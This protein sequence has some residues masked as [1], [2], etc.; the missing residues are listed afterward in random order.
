[1][2][3]TPVGIVKRSNAY[4]ADPTRI[5]IQPE[6]PE[7][8]NKRFD[9]GDLENDFGSMRTQGFYAHKPLL[10]K[11]VEGDPAAEFEIIDG[12]R[13]MTFVKKLLSE[14]VAFPEGIPVVIEDK[15]TTQ[16][17][18]LVKMVTANT[19]KPFAPL[20]E[21]YMFKAMR[22]EN[23]TL[24]EIGKATG[25]NHLHVNNALALLEATPE[26]IAAVASGEINATRAKKIAVVARGDHET[27]KQLTLDVKAA[28]TDK[29][30][31]KRVD[32]KIEDT[33]QKRA[34]KEG[35][36]LKVRALT[37]E[38][39]CELGSGIAEYLQGLLADTGASTP[40]AF[41]SRIKNDPELVA[42][43]TMG[44]LHGLRRAAGEK[45]ELKL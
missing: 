28:G 1:M 20:E 17:Q 12:E 31:R 10:V 8:R 24:E 14:G 6:G 43:Y 22:A 45:I 18:M 2:S 41:L 36:T 39:L 16:A 38:Q 40:E 29:A 25:R 19:G 11:R 9:L 7:K 23:M 33:R 34:E 4:F 32:L 26:L 37:D 27:Q 13:R 44:A 30:S 35:R 42:A 21:A 3:S 15:K 5:R